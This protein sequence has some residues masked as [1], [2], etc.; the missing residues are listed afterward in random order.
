MRLRMT[1]VSMSS[2]LPPVNEWLFVAK[3][4]LK[5]DSTVSIL[6]ITPYDVVYCKILHLALLRIN[7]FVQ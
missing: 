6:L 5:H 2:A 4:K 3:H 1:L 7:T